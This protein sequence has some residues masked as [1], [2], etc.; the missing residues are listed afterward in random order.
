MTKTK[1]NTETIYKLEVGKTE[2][3]E[4]DRETALAD[5]VNNGFDS[6]HEFLDNGDVIVSDDAYYSRTKSKLEVLIA[7]DE[8][9]EGDRVYN[10]KSNKFGDVIATKAGQLRVQYEGESRSTSVLLTGNWQKVES[11]VKQATELMDEVMPIANDKD[12]LPNPDLTIGALDRE[13]IQDAYI[14]TLSDETALEKIK[15]IHGEIVHEKEY[16]ENSIE[17]QYTKIKDAIKHKQNL[18]NKIPVL[19][20]YDLAELHEQQLYLVEY[21][22]FETCV[23]KEFGIVR[24]YGYELMKAAI[25]HE[26]ARLELGEDQANSLSI[27]AL[28][29]F[30]KTSITI[31][32]RLGFDGTNADVLA[33]V[34]ELV[35]TAIRSAV[36]IVPKRKDGTPILTQQNTKAAMETIEYFATSNTV[37][38][39]GEQIPL[40]DANASGITTVAA[41]NHALHILTEQVKGKNEYLAEIYEKRKKN[42]ELGVS[43]NGKLSTQTEIYKGLVPTLEIVCSQHKETFVVSI[44]NGKMQTACGCRWFINDNTKDL[45]CYECNDKAVV[46]GE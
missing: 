23:E 7:T 20:G 32:K 11:A 21:P 6:Q 17:T 42:T 2:I 36:N 45:D 30:A 24:E 31:G 28:G 38:V 37:E 34:S 19:I 8:I 46:Q 12:V 35:R 3:T 16:N 15:T 9:K 14:E 13:S 40:G 41:K 1:E 43:H 26:Q 25:I 33:S 27:K 10:E 44:G 29:S 4:T 39:D 22:D 5:C 18:L